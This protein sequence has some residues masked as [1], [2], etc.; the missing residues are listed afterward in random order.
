MAT[1]ATTVAKYQLLEREFEEL[2][3]ELLRRRIK[4]ARVNN[5]LPDAVHN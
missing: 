1:C 2:K 3:A 4:S 5:S